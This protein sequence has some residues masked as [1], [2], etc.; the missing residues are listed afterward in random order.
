MKVA[1]ACQESRLSSD[2][3]ERFAR[4]PFYFVYDTESAHTTKLASGN[5]SKMPPDGGLSVAVALLD[6]EVDAVIAGKFGRRVVE[7]L[8]GADVAVYEA[9]KLA[10]SCALDRFLRE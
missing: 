9:P 5:R 10:G 3:A 2:V 6:A 4:A 7:F 8:S 1:I